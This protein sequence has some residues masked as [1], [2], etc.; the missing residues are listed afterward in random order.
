MLKKDP[1]AR[2]T[3]EEI[4]AHPWMTQN[5]SLAPEMP[6]SIAADHGDGSRPSAGSARTTIPVHES[7][8]LTLGDWDI[9]RAHVLQRIVMKC[10][11]MK[12]TMRSLMPLS[13]AITP[14]LPPS[15]SYAV[16]I[17][18]RTTIFAEMSNSSEQV[19]SAKSLQKS[20]HFS[21]DVNN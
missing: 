11:G 1:E 21:S 19:T 13:V 12:G 10:C 3:M 15:S 8:K 14:D 18:K 17:P 20:K 16:C 5:S 7:A 4:L 2:I 6:L 9:G